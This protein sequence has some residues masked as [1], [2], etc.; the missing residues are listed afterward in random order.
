MW[1]QGRYRYYSIVHVSKSITGGDAMNWTL[2]SAGVSYL[3]RILEEARKF[4]P[5]KASVIVN[6]QF[7]SLDKPGFFAIGQS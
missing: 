2:I 3:R 4:L 1:T 5:V 7:R 6:T